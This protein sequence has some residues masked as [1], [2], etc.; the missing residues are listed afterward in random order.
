MTT[1]RDVI[2]AIV[3]FTALALYA[4]YL[5]RRERRSARFSTETV[6]AAALCDLVS[7]SH[8]GGDR[9]RVHHTDQRLIDALDREAARRR[10]VAHSAYS[11]ALGVG[12]VTLTRP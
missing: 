4:W 10:L 11:A 6:R 9:V 5:E 1:P 12:R 2:V 8:N 3:L 7:D